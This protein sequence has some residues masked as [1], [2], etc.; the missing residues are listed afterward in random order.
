M[1]SRGLAEGAGDELYKIE[2][3]G[4]D[5]NGEIVRVI[6]SGRETIF[7][8]VKKLVAFGGEGDDHIYVEEGV[9]SDVEFHGGNGNDVFIYDGSGSAALYGDAGDDYLATGDNSTFATLFGGD[10][11]DYI[12]HNGIGAGHDRWWR[13]RR[14]DLRQHS[15]TT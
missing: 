12:V 4:S 5:A 3:L 14:Q 9:T 2:H 10:G 6:F 7:K 15:A 13:G 1:P 8:G 11:I